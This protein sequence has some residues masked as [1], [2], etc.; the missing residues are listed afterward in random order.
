LSFDADLL[1]FEGVKKITVADKVDYVRKSVTDMNAII[2][3]EKEE[4]LKRE[5]QLA[6]FQRKE[7]EV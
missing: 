3:Q 7:L 5:K 2:S 1:E 4:E 6:E